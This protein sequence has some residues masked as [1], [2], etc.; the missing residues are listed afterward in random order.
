MTYRANTVLA[1]REGKVEPVKL[2][3]DSV[4]LPLK[5]A[6]TNDNGSETVCSVDGKTNFE[7]VIHKVYPDL[8]DVDHTTYNDRAIFAATNDNVDTIKYYILS[9]KMHGR[10]QVFKSI[11]TSCHNLM[12]VLQTLD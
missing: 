6:V 10:I 4:A 9:N 2:Q 1:V 7:D 11:F 5:H 12:H 3:D 8:L